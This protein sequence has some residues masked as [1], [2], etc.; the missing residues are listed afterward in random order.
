[1]P[2]TTRRAP[3]A[4]ANWKM[5]M[6]IFESLAYTR[7][8]AALVGPLAEAVTIVLCPAYT[9]LHAVG[10]ALQDT[11]IALGAQDLHPGP[12][13][14]HTGAVSAPLLADVGCQWVLLGHWELRRGRGEDDEAVNAKVH[15]ALQANLRPIPL[16]GE[17]AGEREQVEKALLARLPT[18]FAGCTPDQVSRTALVYEPEWTIGV[19][20]PASPDHVA[21]GCRIIR[22]WIEDSFG[23]P[24]A[25]AIPIVYGGSVAP[26]FAAELLAAPDVDGLGAS[27]KGR[28]P[29]AF[30]EIVALV[31]GQ[32]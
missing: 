6:T 20:E 22:G 9:A 18:I 1:M 8:L 26:A 29:Q 11:P 5:A 27:R 14:A 25:G 15:A 23:V 21:R 3:M 17:G 10:L 24:A 12:G 32:G 2:S 31:A 13:E 28:D 30:S 4:I 19:A 7:A 16:I